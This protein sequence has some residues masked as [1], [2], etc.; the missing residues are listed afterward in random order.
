MEIRS[1]RVLLTLL[2]FII[3]YRIFT[4]LLF[5]WNAAKYFGTLF[6]LLTPNSL[7]HEKQDTKTRLSLTTDKV[8]K[9][10]AQSLN[11]VDMKKKLTR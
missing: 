1:H 9:E 7:Y 2:E 3:R 8:K 4:D 5:S 10:M 11:N 6:E